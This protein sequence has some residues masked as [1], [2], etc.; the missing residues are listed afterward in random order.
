MQSFNQK[1]I[2][3]TQKDW[4]EVFAQTE[5]SKAKHIPMNQEFV[6]YM[7]RSNSLTLKR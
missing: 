3:K 7:N 4:A 1:T 5:H 6:V 2:I